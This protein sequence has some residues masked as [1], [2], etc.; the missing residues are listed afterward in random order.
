M[1]LS[2]F[3]K[4]IGVVTAVGVVA[5]ALI[6][7][8]VSAQGPGPNDDESKIRQGFLIA[9]VPLNLNR[10]NRARVGLGSYLVN[11]VG[12]CNDCHTWPNYAPGGDPYLGEP[13]QVNAEGYMGGGRLFFGPVISRN[14]TPD[15]TGRP[16]GG[17]SYREFLEIMRTGVDPDQAHP[18]FGPLLQVMP[19]SV[20]Q[21]MTDNDLR[22]I[23]EYL[24]AIPCVEGE[25]GLPNPRP[26][27]TRCQ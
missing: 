17:A 19:W 24:S 26:N 22:A 23:Y 6:G 5:G 1:N 15:H 8:R 2:R 14:L 7:P 4:A 27:G 11:A 20:Y 3:V 16:A 10:R 18:Q 13:K 9:P 12:G 21:D 25:P